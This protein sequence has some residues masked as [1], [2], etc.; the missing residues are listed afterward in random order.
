MNTPNRGN[1]SPVRSRICLRNSK[2]INRQPAL[3]PQIR[4]ELDDML[5]DAYKQLRNQP[6]KNIILGHPTDICII[7]N[8]ILKDYVHAIYSEYNIT[9]PMNPEYQKLDYKNRSKSI[10]VNSSGSKTYITPKKSMKMADKSD[11]HMTKPRKSN[12]EKLKIDIR[13]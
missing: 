10:S 6:K 2:M 12:L 11:R 3:I 9:D 8:N 5:D 13:K 7:D 4:I 1:R